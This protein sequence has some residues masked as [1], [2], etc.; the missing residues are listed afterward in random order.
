MELSFAIQFSGWSF[1][2]AGTLFWLGWIMLP[3]HIGIYFKPKD[4][5]KVQKKFHF[6]IWMY[7]IHIFGMVISAI[8]LISL[9]SFLTQHPARVVAWPGIG[10]ATAGTFVA[11]LAAAFYYHHGA[12]GALETQ[13]M[14]DDE[15]AAFVDS[16]QVDNEYI[17]CLVRF[18]RVFTGLGLLLLGWSIFQWAFVPPF[19]GVVAALLGFAAIAVTMLMP[20]HWSLYTPIFHLL[21]LW[22]ITT[23]IAILRSGIQISA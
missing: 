14:S 21:P 16:L 17:T 12:W 20:D 8:A 4:F 19:I 2:T 1:I 15:L 7:R 13:G 22:F 6:W 18:G 9:A 5:E 3:H 11:A 23:G 10:V